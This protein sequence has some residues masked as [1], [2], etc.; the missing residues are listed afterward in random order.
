MKPMIPVQ[1]KF[2]VIATTPAAGY[3]FLVRPHERAQG[4]SARD[5]QVRHVKYDQN[6]A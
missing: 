5:R 4:L 1:V 2:S 6:A 3:L